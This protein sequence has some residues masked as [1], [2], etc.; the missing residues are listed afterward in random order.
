ME[1]QAFIILNKFKWGGMFYFVNN[2]GL[3]CFKFKFPYIKFY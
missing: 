1:G 3:I 2:D